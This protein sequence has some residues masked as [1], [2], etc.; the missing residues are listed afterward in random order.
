MLKLFLYEFWASLPQGYRN[1]LLRIPSNV[2]AYF[3]F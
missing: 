1:I 3:Y 2:F